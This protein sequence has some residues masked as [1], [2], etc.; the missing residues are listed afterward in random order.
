MGLLL[1]VLACAFLWPFAVIFLLGLFA[2]DHSL[3]WVT[4]GAPAIVIIAAVLLIFV[5]LPT[6]T[7][8]GFILGVIGMI[9]YVMS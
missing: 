3:K 4:L 5:G 9:V 7:L 2:A 1:Y 6:Y 8:V